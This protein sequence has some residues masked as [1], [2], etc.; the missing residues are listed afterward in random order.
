MKTSSL[1]IG[2]AVAALLTAASGAA[3]AQSW[4]DTTTVSGRMYYDVSS[5]TRKVDGVTS[6]STSGNALGANNTNGTGFDIKRFY[7]GV[8]H[9]FTDMFSANVTTDFQYNST[10][11]ATELYLKKA[12]FDITVSP[13]FDVKIGATDLPWV[14]YAEGIYGNRYVENTLIDRKYAFKPGASVAG[15]GT[16][17]DWGLHAAGTFGV[18]ADGNTLSYQVSLINGNGYKN[19]SRTK[20][21]DWE[22]RL[23]AVVGY[24]WN[25]AIGGYSGKLGQSVTGVATPQTA[26][27]FDALAAWVGD[28]GRVGVE[29]FSANDYTSTLVKSTTPDKAD[30]YSVFGTYRF[31]HDWST[32]GR[33][34]DV[35]PSK[36]MNPSTKDRYYNVGVTYSAFKNVDFSLVAKHEDASSVVSA[37]G[38]KTTANELG[39]F[40]QF[41]Y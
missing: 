21:M 22:G 26:T 7:I 39:I 32:F 24:Q 1:L 11:G 4:A 13:Q 8:D 14:P 36:T 18:P 27:R 34:D 30:G 12:Y 29:Y 5:V 6:D 20:T 35:K 3:F 28:Q 23:S 15:F 37:V 2:A 19:P 16:S 41:R 31:N 9:K 38:H 17:S 33:Y 10:L 25:F 40:S